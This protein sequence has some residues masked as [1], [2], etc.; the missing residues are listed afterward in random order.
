MAFSNRLIQPGLCASLLLV[1][2][3]TGFAQ[4]HESN[5]T[6]IDSFLI[7]RTEV[8]IGQ[9]ARFASVTGLQTQAEKAGG[10]QTYEG[11]WVQRKGWTWRTPFGLPANPQ[12][13]VVHITFDEA[14]A[15]CQ[16]A[17]K[18]LTTDDQWLRAAYTEQRNNPPAGFV[19]GQ[20]YPY[21]TGS[22]PSG[23]NCLDECGQVTG[24]VA[25]SKPELTS[26]GQG[27]VPVGITAP[28]VNGLWDMGANV[29]E[30]TD[31]GSQD[32]RPTRGG[33]WWYGAAQMHRNH[34]QT[35][36]PQTAVVYIGFRCSKDLSNQTKP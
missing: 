18:R 31:G 12:E 33:S 7:D 35:K 1:P 10:G 9:F 23:A 24:A 25:S 6:R 11:G 29:W 36:P 26:R 22:N 2:C 19:K 32:Q 13:P 15:Y 14:K 28:G 16:W 34:L 4:G 21:P 8:S 30:W 20:S 5:M 27:H 17:G 3:A